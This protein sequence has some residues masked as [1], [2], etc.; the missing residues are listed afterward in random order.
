MAA[1]RVNFAT[2]GVQVAD[3]KT[4]KAK[5]KQR[6]KAGKIRKELHARLAEEAREKLRD[7][8]LDFLGRSEPGVVSGFHPHGSEIDCTV[9]MRRLAGEGWTTCLPVVTGPAKPLTFREWAHDDELEAGV[10]DIPVPGEEAPEVK[11]DVLLVPLLAY[12]DKGYRLGYGGGFYDRTIELAR[13]DREVVTVGVAF[14]EQRVK[15]VPHLDHD[16]PLDWMLTEAG[17]KR[18]RGAD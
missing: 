8:G 7:T 15:S 14:A 9:L 3:E 10:W 2:D 1:S 12:D 5:R 6:K 18:C 16:E 11:P 13:A 4:A 17:P